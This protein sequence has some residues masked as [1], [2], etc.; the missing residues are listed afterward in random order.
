MNKIENDNPNKCTNENLENN[1][2]ITIKKGKFK[3][4]PFNNTCLSNLF[5][6]G[7]V[8]LNKDDERSE[9][10][11][12]SQHQSQDDTYYEE[13]YAYVKS[14]WLHNETYEKL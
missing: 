11:K 10:V 8:K 5:E 4:H 2:K 7:R 3:R 12:E 14:K 6:E 9:T 1:Q 13:L